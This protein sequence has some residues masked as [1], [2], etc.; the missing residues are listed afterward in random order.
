MV[1]GL[2]SC[3]PPAA[4][5]CGCASAGLSSSLFIALRKPLMVSPRSEPRFFRR[6]VPNTSTTTIRMTTQCFQSKMPMHAVLAVNSGSGA[7]RLLGVPG[8]AEAAVQLVQHGLRMLAE[9]GEHDQAVEPEVGGLVDQVAAVAAER[10]VLGRDDGLDRFFADLLQDLVQTLVV[11]A[12][13]V[14][15][16]R[17]RALAR[18]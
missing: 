14:G 15:A 6:L 10:R 5:C 2:C 4:G 18:L 1:C 16:V 8:Q 12:G 3:S 9:R 17:R 11:Q 13:H 7:R